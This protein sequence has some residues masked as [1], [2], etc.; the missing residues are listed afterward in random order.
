MTYDDRVVAR[1]DVMEKRLNGRL[2]DIEG[3][4]DQHAVD[5]AQAKGGLKAARWVFTALVSVAGVF[6]FSHIYKQ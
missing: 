5:I 6:G 3:K 4:V 1:I 2:D